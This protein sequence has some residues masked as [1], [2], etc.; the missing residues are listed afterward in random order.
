[1]KSDHVIIGGG[2]A[3]L[4]AAIR[5]AE[6]GAKPLVI[7]SG[8]YPSHKVCG[9]FF[10]PECL[11]II[12]GWDIHP[13]QVHSACLHA[14]G[15]ASLT[16]DFRKPAGSLSH[17]TFDSLLLEKARNAGARVLTGTKATQFSHSLG[18]HII[19]LSNGEIVQAHNLILAVGRLPQILP[20]ATLCYV[21]LKA[22]FKGIPLDSTLVMHYF[23]GGYIGLS[24]IE[25]DKVNVAC[26]VEKGKVDGYLGPEAF[27]ERLLSKHEKL[28]NTIGR[29]TNLF[30]KWMTGGIPEFGV[31]ARVDWPNTYCVGDAAGTIPPITG[32]GLSM[33]IRGGVMVA[34]YAFRNDPNGYRKEWLGTFK[35]SITMG[36]GLQAM[37]IR[38]SLCSPLMQLGKMFPSILDKIYRLTR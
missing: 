35:P 22:H 7:E 27:I 21:G 15:G 4:C 28:G 25:D 13:V 12:K 14:E 30:S 9:E 2:V 1:M 3:G 29:G 19:K 36:K 5:L 33:A 18:E 8:E 17:Y 32:M 23:D 26:L 24:P 31:K 38:P 11:T 10:S 20:E 34:E 6:L 16:Y 37:A